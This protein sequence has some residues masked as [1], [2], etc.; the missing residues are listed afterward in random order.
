MGFGSFEVICRKTYQPLCILVGPY[1]NST[2]SVPTDILRAG[3]MPKCYARSIILANTMI[4]NVGTAFIHLGAIFVLGIMIVSIRT[5]YTAIG[6]EEILHFFYLYTLLTF[7]SLVVDTGVSPPGSSSYPYLVSIQAG[8]TSASC[9][10]LVINGLLGFQ[11]YEDGTRRS[12]WSLRILCSLAFV[13]TFVIGLITFQGWGGSALDPSHTTG[14]FFVLYVLNAIMIVAYFVS[15]M[16]LAIFVLHDIWALGAMILCAFFFIVGQVLMYGFSDTICIQVKHYIDGVFFATVCNLFAV[17]MVYKFWDM[18]TTEDME[19]G[20]SNKE[21][22]WT[23][24]D[25]LDHRQDDNSVYASST[26]PLTRH[27]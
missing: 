25:L 26:F 15:E 4:F 17:M 13:L 21:T 7:I 16:I 18:T 5:K 2:V 9:C 19:F 23:V 14:L 22:A 20:V 6:R 10:C 12:R 24:D 27:Q 8:L 1:T 3:I 11:L